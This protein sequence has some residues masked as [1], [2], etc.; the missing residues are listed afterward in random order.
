MS[1]R[2]FFLNKSNICIH[3]ILIVHFYIFARVDSRAALATKLE[4]TLEIVESIYK[5]DLPKLKGII[6]PLLHQT[7]FSKMLTFCATKS[8]KVLL[9][10]RPSCTVFSPPFPMST[11][12]KIP[13]RNFSAINIKLVKK[14]YESLNSVMSVNWILRTTVDVRHEYISR[15]FFL[16]EKFPV[17]QEIKCIAT[18]ISQLR[19]IFSLLD[20]ILVYHVKASWGGGYS[21][22]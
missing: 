20:P 16:N 17:S 5:T 6:K 13:P 10:R 15:H 1:L 12:F 8:N 4:K 7:Y 19:L 21:L 14:F 3:G 22:K 2:L 18:I 9:F 11:A